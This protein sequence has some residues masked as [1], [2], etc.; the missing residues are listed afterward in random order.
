MFT[1]TVAR[2][3]VTVEEVSAVLRDKL[4]S[5]YQITPSVTSRGFAKEVPDDANAML[6]TGA[7]LARAN[8]RILP[9][10]DG[11]EIRV[12][13]GATYPGLI[14]FIDRIG[15]ARKVHQILERAPELAESR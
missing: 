11:T 13:P 5:G 3:N 8:I 15:I 9:G 6:V 10:A 12:S 1:I 4:G 14:R 7:W 2:S